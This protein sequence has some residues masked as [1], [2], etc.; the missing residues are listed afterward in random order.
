MSKYCVNCLNYLPARLWDGHY[1]KHSCR[2]NTGAISLVS[3][4]P[5][6]HEVDPERMRRHDGA[7]GPTGKL[8][9]PGVATL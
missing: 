4:K 2:Y 9:V 3:G 1:L 6:I 8:Y 7:C 5:I